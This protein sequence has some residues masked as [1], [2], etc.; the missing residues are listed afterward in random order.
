MIKLTLEKFNKLSKL[1]GFDEF[2]TEEFQEDW[3][4]DPIYVWSSKDAK[5]IKAEL[6]EKGY[7]WEAGGDLDSFDPSYTWDYP[8]IYF[9]GKG[10]RLSY[11][12]VMFG[13]DTEKEP[14]LD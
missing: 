9:L 14:S 11:A 5:M 2:P 6:K 1:E 13:R 12:P 3:E 4:E 10:K 7:R 8:V